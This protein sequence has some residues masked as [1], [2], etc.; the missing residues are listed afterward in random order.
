[1]KLCKWS[2]ATAW[3]INIRQRMV[4]VYECVWYVY[5]HSSYVAEYGESTNEK[6]GTKKHTHT[7]GQIFASKW[8]GKLSVRERETKREGK[9]S[10][11]KTKNM[12][13]EYAYV[14]SICLVYWF[15]FIPNP[16]PT[17]FGA[18]VRVIFCVFS[19]THIARCLTLSLS[20]SPPLRLSLY[21]VFFF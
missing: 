8:Y 16:K 3:C 19:H 2:K 6:D 17:D 10:H 12:T 18:V 5:I 1:M 15:H 13:H 20:L 14:G 4:F 11:T 7:H 21:F 9:I